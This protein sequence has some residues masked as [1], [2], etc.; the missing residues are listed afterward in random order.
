M[1]GDLRGKIAAVNARIGFLL[2]ESRGALRGERNF[3]P[4]QLRE[5]AQPISEM[6]PVMARAK[7]LTS[8][9][10]AIEAEVA[11]YKQNLSELHT[12]LEQVYM[13]LI[14]RRGQMDEARKHLD[15]VSKWAAATRLIR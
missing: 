9:Q 2:E 15:A 3:G 14:A 5:L 7:E 4:E 6:A 11:L 8:Q 12:T 10:P 1:L 13:M